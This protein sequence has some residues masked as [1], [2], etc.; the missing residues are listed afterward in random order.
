MT[1]FMFILLFSSQVIL[2]VFIVRIK[3][4]GDQA[5]SVAGPGTVYNHK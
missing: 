2:D 5:F 1:L 4:T 3:N